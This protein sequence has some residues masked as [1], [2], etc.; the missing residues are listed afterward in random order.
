MMENAKAKCN[1]RLKESDR[2]QETKNTSIIN[3]TLYSMR[4]RWRKHAEMMVV[5]IE[6]K[7]GL[8]RRRRSRTRKTVPIKYKLYCRIYGCPIP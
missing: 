8:R 5:T 3:V 6:W 2:R 4:R 7:R 1:G